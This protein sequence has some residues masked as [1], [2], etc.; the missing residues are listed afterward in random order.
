MDGIWVGWGIQH[1]R[2][3]IMYIGSIAH[4]YIYEGSI[5][6]WQSLNAAN[7]MLQ[8]QNMKNATI[9]TW[10][11][12]PTSPEVL[13]IKLKQPNTKTI[14]EEKIPSKTN[15]TSSIKP[16][17]PDLKR[18]KQRV[19]NLTKTIENRPKLTDQTKLS[20]IK[21]TNEAELIPNDSNTN[22]IDQS[23]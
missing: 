21:K 4:G 6:I 3:P 5:A 19:I 10:Q 22:K 14:E 8:Q 2:V 16:I 15:K 13:T 9:N 20:K 11:S 7:A 23:N 12:V 18:V 1:L 17:E